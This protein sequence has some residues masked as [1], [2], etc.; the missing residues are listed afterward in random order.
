M[1]FG[2]GHQTTSSFSETDAYQWLVRNAWKFGFIL[3]YPEENRPWQF[4]FVGR[5][6]AELI[7]ENGLTLEDYL[8]RVKF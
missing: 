5:I 1:A 6:H 4:R 3:R 7:Y 2:S 8:D